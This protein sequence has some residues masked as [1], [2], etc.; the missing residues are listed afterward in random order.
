GQTSLHGVPEPYA[1]WREQ[2][3]GCAPSLAQALLPYPQYC[4]N[5]QGLNEFHG[6]SIYHSLQAKVEKRFSAGTFVLVSYTFA[7]LITSG[8]DNIQQ[9][10]LTWN[11]VSG[12]I[13]PFE[14]ERNRALAV[15][16]VAHVLSAALVWDIPVGKGRKHL[17]KGGVTNT[18]L[19]GWQLST[20]FRYSS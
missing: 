2:M 20:V 14:N 11:G 7:K 15:D 3:T 5:L 9:E 1:G 16:D 10:S 6:K 18:L 19:G 13:S 4:S 12:V 8:T 17:D